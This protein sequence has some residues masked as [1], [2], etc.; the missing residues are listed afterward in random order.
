MRLQQ[1]TI[2]KFNDSRNIISLLWKSYNLIFQ[3]YIQEKI[4]IYKIYYYYVV[5]VYTNDKHIH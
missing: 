1:T 4:I 3:F 5:D 2:T